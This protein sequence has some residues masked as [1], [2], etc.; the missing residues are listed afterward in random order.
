MRWRFRRTRTSLSCMSRPICSR[1]KALGAVKSSTTPPSRRRLPA[2][3]AAMPG[4]RPLRQWHQRRAA[5]HRVPNLQHPASGTPGA[6][7]PRPT[8]A[9]SGLPYHS[10]AGRPLYQAMGERRGGLTRQS[11]PAVPDP[12]PADAPGGFDVQPLNDGALRFVNSH[13]LAIRPPRRRETHH[14]TPSPSRMNPS[15]SPWTAR[16]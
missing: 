10:T 12:S 5:Q 2:G 15:A 6:L 11:H 3:S 13:G 9:A 16:P 8:E 7:N 14:P 1:T 4:R